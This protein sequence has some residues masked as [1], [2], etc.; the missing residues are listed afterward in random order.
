MSVA[1]AWP[2]LVQKRAETARLLRAGCLAGLLVLAAALADS[3]VF[4][5][6]NPSFGLVS[7]GLLLMSGLLLVSVDRVPLAAQLLVGGFMG[8]VSLGLFLAP[9]RAFLGFQSCAALILLAAL[10]LD[11][12]WPLV[13]GLLSAG[14]GLFRL[15]AAP[16]PEP[17]TMWLLGSIMYAALGIFLHG[18]AAR[19][20]KMRALAAVE[21]STL[22]EMGHTLQSYL[23]ESVQHEQERADAELRL[24]RMLDVIAD[25]IIMID[26]S[27]RIILFNR[28]AERL[29]GYAAPEIL[30]QPLDLLLP[31]EVHQ[32]HRQHIQ[33]FAQGPDV[34]RG[35]GARSMEL[36]GVRKDGTRF[37]LE[38]SISKLTEGQRLTFTVYLQDITDRKR[39]EQDRLEAAELRAELEKE[40][41][42][43]RFKE[44]FLSLVSHEFRTPLAVILSSKELLERYYERLLP[45]KR[46][47]HYN[48]IAA[49]VQQMLAMLDNIITVNKA[50]SGMLAFRPRPV[51]VNSLCREI[52]DS[53]RQIDQQHDLQFTAEDRIG[54]ALVDPNLLHHILSN[55]LLNALKYS[56]PGT[57]V[58]LES[59]LSE[60]GSEIVFRVSDE[61]IGIPQEDQG[62]IFEPFFRASNIHH[63]AGSGLGLV[64]VRN[65]VEAHGGTLR[66]ESTPG[67][68]TKFEI[69]LPLIRPMQDGAI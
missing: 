11:G 19:V 55:L 43:L 63:Q 36:S 27:H 28:S 68:G 60:D 24:M 49:Q 66:L 33:D 12:R 8:L 13:I 44:R 57:T 20:H 46:A 10:L 56:E 48:K 21:S 4:T 7:L 15:L 51:P 50:N 59:A 54:V 5:R 25:A 41:E 17:G 45:E 2:P 53:V 26:E 65:S 37:P 61:G 14:L 69:R 31:A 29:F 1:R 6:E 52:V 39:V 18:L 32:R 64:I 47:E 38:A 9:Q 40:K 16:V 67:E 58:T 35:M 34:A 42:L 3:F 23:Q 62:L 22:A 30:G